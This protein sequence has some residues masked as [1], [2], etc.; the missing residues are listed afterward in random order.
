MILTVDDD[1]AVSRAVARDLRRHYG[2][3]YRIVRA[4]SGPD[5]LA[6]LKE[7]KL[8]GETVAVLVADYRMPQ[9]SG[10]E[11][12][13]KAMDL[14]PLAR[15]VLLTAYADTHAA[16]DA[17]NVVDLDHYLLKPWD[18]PE[19]KLYPVIDGLLE[20]WRAVGDRAMP[21]TK[22][23]GHRWNQRSWEVRQFLARNQFPFRAF[24]ADEPKGK[25]LLDAAGLD[26]MALP[27][28]ITEKGE[29]L[30]EP[31]DGQLAELLGLSTEPSLPMY[32]LAVIGGGPA[33]LASAVYG[34]SEGL[35][36]VL[37]ERTTTGGQAGR[38]SRIEN[39]LGFP[40]GVSGAELTNSARRQAERFGAE[41]ITTR[42]V[43]KLHVGE[44]APTIEFEDG[45]TIGAR[46][47]ILA[48]GV[49]YQELRV[50][51][52]WSDPDNPDGCN[53][54]GRGV[55]YGASVSDA[56]EC[57]DEDVYIVG[58]ANSAGQAAMFMSKTA[59]SVTLLVRG[60]S[61]EASM[62]HYL[63]EQIEANPKIHVKTC[64]QVVDTCGEDDHLTGLW[65]ED[66]QSG[67]REKV[68]CGRLCC[69]IGATPRTD[70]LDG[71]LALDDRGFVLAGP[72]LKD[73]CGWDRD[74]PPH[75]LETSVP[76]V[77]VAGDVRSE[78]AKRVAAAVGEGSMA[79]MLVHRY[80]AEA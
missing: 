24:M 34:A 50:V 20:D 58:G 16:I 25:Q 49:E 54:V 80:L 37:I 4:E 31:S 71:V 9:M 41:V 23:I 11:F 67:T 76:G 28:V 5:A 63:I 47:V 45:S 14:F 36:T 38:S 43:V 68:D 21:F 55:Y 61:L 79:V 19:E 51:G 46:S 10:I 56:E 66:K 1:P 78:S 7:L 18:P 60:P 59:K 27:V 75:H 8:R 15:R 69:F 65:L 2:E 33:G 72:D 40:I 6:T 48:T 32:D 13:E 70:W 12:L 26:G 17:I 29:A 22:V 35:E 52:C 64:T 77:F 3:R 62:S 73:V 53:Y 57:R 42:D 74:R 39:Y 30:V 44:A